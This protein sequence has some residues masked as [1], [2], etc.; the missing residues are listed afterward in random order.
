MRLLSRLGERERTR[1]EQTVAAYR[2]ALKEFTQERVPL[3]W[4]MSTG[5]QGVAM[6]IIAKRKEDPVMAARHFSRSRQHWKSHA[7]ADMRRMLLI[8]KRAC[9]R[10][11]HYSV[12]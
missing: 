6:M 1:L 12:G 11:R 2:E 9:P 8:T 7:P 4:A 3:Q 10:P 5:N